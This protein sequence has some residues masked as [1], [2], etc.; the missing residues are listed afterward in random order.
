MELPTMPR[1]G[2]GHVAVRFGDYNEVIV[3]MLDGDEVQDVTIEAYA[4]PVGG[5]VIVEASP[6]PNCFGPR[7]E[8]RHGDVQLSRRTA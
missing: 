3:V 1:Q 8:I 5:W 2:E 7:Y 6:C 4:T